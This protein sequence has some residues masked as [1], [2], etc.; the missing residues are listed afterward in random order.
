MKIKN[1]LIV[2]ILIIIIITSYPNIVQ[3]A[4][5]SVDEIVTEAGEFISIGGGG[6][7]TINGDGLKNAS[8]MIYNML[9]TVAVIIAVVVGAFLGMKFM[10]SSA[11]DKAKVKETLIPFIVGCIV[12]FGGFGIWKVIVLVLSG[13]TST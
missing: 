3:A 1:I 4:G 9:L 2:F 8:D 13:A 12:V 5:H 11:E 10:I 7:G 6:S